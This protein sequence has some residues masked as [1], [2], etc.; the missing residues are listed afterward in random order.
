MKDKKN[1]SEKE[2]KKINIFLLIMIAVIFGAGGAFAGIIIARPYFVNTVYNAPLASGA[3]TSQNS[4]REANS[5]IENAK[6]IIV[7]QENKVNDTISSSQNSLVGIFKKKDGTATSSVAQIDNNKFDAANYY[8]LDEEIGEGL[9]V[10]SDGWILTTDFSKNAADALIAK[11]YVAITKDKKIYSIDK[12]V[13]SGIDSYLF[14]HL[15]DA[16]ELP[17][18]S[19]VSKTDLT[20]SQSLVALNWRSESYLTSIVDKKEQVQGVRNSDGATENMVLSNNLG[21]YFDNAFIFSLNSEVVGF[22]DKKSGLMPIDNFWPLIKGLLQKTENKL[23]SLGITYVNLDDFAIST[24]GYDKGALIYPNGKLPAVKDGSAAKAAQLQAGDIIVSVDN[25]EIS[26][27]KDLAE[28]IQKYSAGDLIN[29]IYRRNGQ[30]N[31]VKI[32]LGELISQK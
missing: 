2:N 12:I 20:N 4:L 11:N 8:K 29:V 31:S 27:Q 21:D 28:V 9:V 23:P 17:V 26:G 10:T 7:S 14:I 24:P 3:D 1:I 16:S 13:R 19:F 30:E 32:K 5:I 22:F 25:T 6:K 15:V 18:K